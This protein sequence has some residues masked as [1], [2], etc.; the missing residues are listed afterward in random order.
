MSLVL[1]GNS[2][3]GDLPV[4]Q[5]NGKPL[6]ITLKPSER[7]NELLS[8]LRD[9]VTRIGL[10]PGSIEKMDD[11]QDAVDRW[12]SKAL[13]QPRE[14]G[15][16][17]QKSVRTVGAAQKLRLEAGKGK[18][19]HNSTRTKAPVKCSKCK[20]TGHT[21]RTCKK[22]EST[23]ADTAKEVACEECDRKFSNAQARST[24]MTLTHKRKK[25]KDTHLGDNLAVETGA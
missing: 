11:F 15:L 12:A 24:H 10:G 18:T 20:M 1:D 23:D 4:F 16:T 14:G 6:A 3:D 19:R 8:V 17:V 22:R 7:R 13:D 25:V 5:V 21:K 9:T 2:S